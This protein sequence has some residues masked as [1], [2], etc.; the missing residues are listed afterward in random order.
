MS[1]LFENMSCSQVV[2]YDLRFLVIEQEFLKLVFLWKLVKCFFFFSLF[3][4]R[5]V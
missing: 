2:G 4:P 1:K 3:I 5:V